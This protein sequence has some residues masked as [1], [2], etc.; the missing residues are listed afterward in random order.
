MRLRILVLF[1]SLTPPA[2]AADALDIVPPSTRVRGIPGAMTLQ[3]RDCRTLPTAETRRRIV[4]V[5]IQQWSFFGSPVAAP[6]DQGDDNDGPSP[7]DRRGRRPRLPPAEAARV[8]PFIA[9]YWAV[10]AEGSWIVARQNDR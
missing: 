6:A 10:T 2:L 7:D 9:G 1:L 8:A 4:D 3:P 5:A